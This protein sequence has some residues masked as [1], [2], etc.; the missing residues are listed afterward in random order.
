MAQMKAVLTRARRSSLK[1]TQPP[2]EAQRPSVQCSNRGQTSGP[3]LR[4]QARLTGGATAL[5]PV[6]ASG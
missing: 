3:A 1:K 5:D 6:S 4:L 2:S